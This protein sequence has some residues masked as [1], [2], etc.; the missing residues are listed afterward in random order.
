MEQM[1]TTSFWVQLQTSIVLLGAIC[2]GTSINLA[3]PYTKLLQK[4]GSSVNGYT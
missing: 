3:G 2:L 4:V 1:R